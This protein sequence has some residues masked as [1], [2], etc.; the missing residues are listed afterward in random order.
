MSGRKGG[1]GEAGAGLELIFRVDAEALTPHSLCV[2][3]L[4]HLICLQS[5]LEEPKNRRLSK[6]AFVERR[7]KLKHQS[8]RQR[9][10]DAHN[11]FNLARV[12]DPGSR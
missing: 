2:Q 6:C 11:N 4:D 9:R 10:S 12:L 5:L 8:Q 1:R 7:H 3:S